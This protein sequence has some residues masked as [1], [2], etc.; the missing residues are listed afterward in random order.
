[1]HHPRPTVRRGASLPL[2]TARAL[3]AL[4]VLSAPLVPT[5]RAQQVVPV[6]GGSYAT[7]PSPSEDSPGHDV[8]GVNT[9]PLYIEDSAASLP[10]PTN[11]WWTDLIV[12]PYAGDLWAR[13]F[14]VSAN[15]AGIRISYPTTWNASGTAFALGTALEVT[16]DVVPVPDA[17]DVMMADFEGG[18]YPAGRTR[19]GTAFA[20]APAAGTLGG[21]SAVG[22]YLGSGLANS[23]NGGDGPTGS[24][25]SPSFTV[26]RDYI[27]FLVGGGNHPGV[28]EVRLV[29]GGSTVMSAT[30]VN[31]ENLRWVTWNVSAYAGQTA[32]I[33]V[34]DNA[35]GGWG[36][37]LADQIFRTN[38]TEAP[39]AR[40]ATTFSPA[41]AK[42]LRWGD[43]NVAFRM[44][45]P[46]GPFMDV[47]LARGVPY[48]W[49]ETS[50]VRPRLRTGA[51]AQFYD[52]AGA[53]LSFPATTDRFAVVIDGKAYGVHAPAG[54]SFTRSGEFVS[55]VPG[56]GYLVVSALPGIA[57]LNTF[58]ARAFAVPRGSALSWSYSPASGK[59]STSWSLDTVA[60]QGSNLDTIQGWLPHH[61]RGTSHN[62][63]FL[64]GVSYATPRG[65]MQ[66]VVGRSGWQIDYP[67]EGIAPTLPLPQVLGKANDFNP[68]TLKKYLDDYAAED[69][70][71]GDTYWGGKSLT[72]LADY[73]LAAKQAGNTTAYEALKHTLRVALADWFTY[74]PGETENYFARYDRWKALVGFNDS[75]GSHEFVDHHFHYGYFTRS[76]GLLAFEDPS[77]AADF[78][79]MATL[80]AKQYANWDR[81]DTNFPFLRTFDVWGGHS[82]AGGFSSPGGNNQESSSE[83]IQSWAGLFML[84]SALGDTAMRDAGAMGYVME[85]AAVR[86]YWLD[87]HG[88]ILPDAYGQSSTGILFDGGQAYATY[89]S[90]DP[91]WMY[92]IQW[93]PVATHLS[94]LGWDRAFSKELMADMIDDR[95]VTLLGGVAG[96]SRYSLW[97]ARQS[98]HGIADNAL[99]Q[100]AAIADITNAIRNAY[101]HNPGY[102]GALNA[103]NPLYNAATGQLHFTVNGDGS[104]SFPPAY[105]TP[106]TLPA[107]LTPP[108]AN[109]STPFEDPVTWNLWQYL[110]INYTPDA[111]RML[112]LYYYDVRGYTAAETSQAADVYSRMGDGLGNVVLGFAA[113][114]D[115]DFYADVHAALWARNDPVARATSMAG[116]V[117]YTAFS[118][119]GLGVP[120]PSRHTSAP[121]SQAYRHPDTGAYRYVV[122]NPASTQ[123][124][125]TVYQSATGAALGSF[126][127]PARTLVS[128][129]LDQA[130]NNIVVSASNP[131]RTIQPGQTVQFTATGY[132][133]YGATFPL[134]TV[135]WSVNAG[136]VINAS[137]LFTA[138]AN[139]DPVI[140]TATSG[141]QVRAYSFR[142]GAAPVLSGVA[143]SPGFE[144]V[145]AGGGLAFT[146]SGL[147]QYGDAIALGAVSWTT[148]VPGASISAGG[149]FTAGAAGTG[150]V[151]ASAGSLVGS[152]VVSVQAVQANLALGTTPTASNSLGGNTPLMAVDGNPGT[153]WESPSGLDNQTFIIDLGARHDLTRVFIDWE[154]AYAATYQVQVSDS[155][156]GPWQTIRDVTKTNAADDDLAVS[157]AGRFVRLNLLTRA[158]GYG[159]SFFEVQVYGWLRGEAVAP[160][161]VRLSPAGATVRSGRALSYQAY[162]FDSASRGGPVAASAWSV[163]GGGSIDTSGVFSA[164]VV[165]GPFTVSGSVG[166]VVGQ[167]SVTV[168][169]GDSQPVEL[170]N[171]APG[172]TASASSVE[173]AGTPAASAIDGNAGTRWSS[174]ASNDQYIEVDLGAPTD[175]RRVVLKWETAY[176]S[177]YRIQVMNTTA[178]AWT[179]VVT[180]TAGD[181][182]EDSH[183]VAVVA[184]HVRMQGD[185]RGTPWGYSLWEFEILAPQ[186]PGA[187]LALGKTATASSQENAARAPGLAVDGSATTRWSSQFN[188]DEWLQVDLGSSRSLSSVTL[189]WEGAYA[190]SYVIEGANVAGGPW[191]QLAADPA[192]NG[193]TDTLTVSGSYRYVRMRGI[194]RATPWGYS[195]WEFEIR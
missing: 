67:F 145:V 121:T 86:E 170:V 4:S 104:L 175:I 32:R 167:T 72:Q 40:Y 11:E 84:G 178:E 116:W 164:S 154:P 100:T 88:D 56:A 109:P 64:P 57:D 153:R 9:R 195:L 148:S 3:L 46:S 101:L 6:G 169:A 97:E 18:A 22:G 120:D 37:I 51:A 122:Y 108:N 53:P 92:G 168:S 172:K 45:Q 134:G 59:I 91:A 146:A 139:A 115:P 163:T 117:Y 152:S 166:G 149:V 141:G 65:A 60:L 28:A 36:H 158:T 138:T 140:V 69:G 194:T 157:G 160:A 191:I 68:A 128:H 35:T 133:Q 1:M 183:D 25:V 15:A 125:V 161:V 131:A 129:G 105:W 177:A 185:A 126:P 186:A 162:A 94:Y 135:N 12:S 95:P 52:A 26:D 50:N 27:S 176:G 58:H 39:A 13:P 187:N 14:T 165:G 181:G 24:L 49:L 44:R 188:N 76:A 31:S 10:I 42:A 98:W 21:Q 19:S 106:A 142:V 5:L 180:E 144:R 16:G 78:G 118:N 81:A 61:Y 190:S 103:S 150:H 137:G 70:Y 112:D 47:S 99:N 119:R 43:W 75:Y 173:G 132:D 83:A 124:T 30:G 79:P 182:G 192:G 171:V 174:A 90:G 189:V 113:Q 2:G 71:G 54:S 147:D 33:E 96:G 130:L 77:F 111:G 23:F 159:F 156:S 29:V 41:S 20:A 114:Y 48:V 63:S 179:T 82:Y 102:V 66:T 127:V 7:H 110:G 38:S 143:V 93:L 85:R 155:A 73:M 123:Q 193:G 8:T 80:V 87:V 136:G 55:S 151:S 184:R 107:S 34:V 74:T 62:L 17:S 89:F